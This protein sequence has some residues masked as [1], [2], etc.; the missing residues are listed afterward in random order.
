LAAAA[1]RWHC[2][3]AADRCRCE[4]GRRRRRRTRAI[5]G[6]LA[7]S[8]PGRAVV[9]RELLEA[10][11]AALAG[12]M[13]AAASAAS[14]A[15]VPEPHIGSSNAVPGA[16]P[17]SASTPAAR[18]SRSGATSASRRQPRLNSASPDVSR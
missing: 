16:Q 10:E 6:P 13:S 18:F 4:K 8:L 12:A 9:P 5:A 11:G 15:I 17:E 3:T 14:I 7:Q 2:A 1:L